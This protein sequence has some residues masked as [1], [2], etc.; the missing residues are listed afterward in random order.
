M[1][2]YFINPYKSYYESLSNIGDL[3]NTVSSM[4]EKVTEA[5]DKLNG[6]K[7]SVSNSSWRELGISELSNEIIPNLV[8]AT[9]T[10]HNNIGNTLSQIA[11]KAN[12]LYK[13]A[14]NL[15]NEDENLNNLQQQLNNLIS[16]GAPEATNPYYSTYMSEK[17]SLQNKVNESKEKCEKLVVNCNTIA[18]AIKS[19]DQ[20]VE[21]FTIVLKPF[22]SNGIAEM[23]IGDSVKDG[24]ML[25]MT[26]DGKEFYVANTKLNL[27]D[28]QEYILKN[29]ITQ[30]DGVLVGLCP[31]FA[32]YYAMDLMRGTYTSKDDMINKRQGPAVRMADTCESQD[33]NDVLKYL[34]EEAV[35]GRVT[36]LQATRSGG[37]RHIVTVVGFDS[38]VKS[39]EDLNKDT[40]LILDNANGKISTL[41]SSGIEGRDLL[42]LRSG[43]P[44]KQGKCY[45]AHGAT[46]AFLNDEV[47]NEAWQAKHGNTT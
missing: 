29:N 3:I 46:D 9:T 21:E 2:N 34:Y 26:I 25:K 33:I 32:Q 6:A 28:Y 12:E 41:G 19:I 4:N 7:S 38:S 27:L 30:N 22:T 8:S 16:R 11:I 47:Y 42:A 1:A 31:I 44:R 10:L 39:W 36:T 5:S 15:K 45:L 40:I 35:N 17:N 37:N 13:E 23:S 43:D 18:N 24:K 14:A 20:S